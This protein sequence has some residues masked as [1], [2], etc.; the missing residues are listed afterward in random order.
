[1]FTFSQVHL[2]N[3]TVFVSTSRDPLLATAVKVSL[4]H[5]ARRTSTNANPTH[6]KTKEAA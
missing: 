5:V 1:M 4:D 2:V 6:A 3:I